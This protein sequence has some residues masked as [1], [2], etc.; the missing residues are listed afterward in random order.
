MQTQR[1]SFVRRALGIAAAGVLFTVAACSGG[2]ARNDAPNSNE[3]LESSLPVAAAALSAGQPEVARRLYLS[4][5]ERFEDAP[6]PVLGLA[7]IA[8]ADNDFGAA[9]KHFVEASS[10]A[11]KAAATRAEALLGAGRAALARER[12]QSARKHFERARKPS[13]GTPSAP[14][15]ENGLAVA[16]TLEEDYPEAEAAFAEALRLAPGDPRISANFVRMLPRGGTHGGSSAPPCR[17]R[18]LPLGG[19]RLPG[20]SPSHRGGAAREPACGCRERGR[21]VFR[22]DAG[23]DL[24]AARRTI[25]ARC[26]RSPTHRPTS[27]S[28]CASR[29]SERR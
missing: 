17:A 10:R 20:A 19:R 23:P 5:A 29:H 26:S 11:R 14:W 9:E 25:R 15:I 22:S 2:P 13:R 7:Y 12:A 3:G 24:C 21:S 6:E 27:A 4:L 28:R 16:A 8:F 1:C 18:L